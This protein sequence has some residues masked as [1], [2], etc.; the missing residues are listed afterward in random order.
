MLEFLYPR[1]FWLL[2]ILIPYLIFE[3]FIKP[4]KRVTITHP[5][6]AL[7]KKISGLTN[8]TKFIP[9]I[10]NI[11]I[12]VLLT[13]ALARPR[14]ALKRQEI[15]GKG[16]DIVMA[17]DIS[18][19]MKAVDFQPGNRL[20]AAKKVAEKFINNRKN[21]RL[22]LVTF[23]ET[24][25]TQCP[26]TLDYNILMTILEGIE[27]DEEANGT[28]I[29]MG[30]ATAVARL[31]ESKAKTKVIILITDGRN[32]KGE[33]DPFTAADLAATYGIKVYSI[34]V[35]RKGEVDYPFDT[36]Y[37]VTYRKV[38]IDIDMDSLNKIAQI[39][40]TERAR[41]ATNTKE[42]EAIMEY[43]DNLEKTEL[44]IKN[45][46]DYVELFYRYLLAAMILLLIQFLFRFIFVKE[47]P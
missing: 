38:K 42:L 46:Y 8:W 27:I 41:Q 14:L 10:I 33:I 11:L 35:G 6:A 25:F 32:N 15:K 43:I 5:Q 39:T 28:A 36:G 31:R 45:Y 18:G 26:L 40:G 44:K 7:L 37:G 2:L 47:I 34:G 19:S 4:K 3:I 21:D 23:A 29:G 16:I 24:A 30:L 12:I 20:E 17:I 13:I 1:W 9:I 22:G